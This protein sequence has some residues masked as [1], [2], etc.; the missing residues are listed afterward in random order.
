M[1]A[2]TAIRQMAWASGLSNAVN[3]FWG[4]SISLAALFCQPVLP[5]QW[6]ERFLG[7]I[8]LRTFALLAHYFSN[9]GDW[10]APDPAHTDG[11]WRGRTALNCPL[12]RRMRCQMIFNLYGIAVGSSTHSAG[13]PAGLP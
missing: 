7:K 3:G 6:A 5:G 12:A 10:V 1:F 11:A 9:K 8:F 2:N 13:G 4:D